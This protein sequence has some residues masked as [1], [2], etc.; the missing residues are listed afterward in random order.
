[1]RRAFGP[2]SA[3]RRGNDML[4]GFKSKTPGKDQ[5]AK[6]LAA[7]D[8]A[9]TNSDT[10]KVGGTMVQPQRSLT[11]QPIVKADPAKPQ[12]TSS[13]GAGMSI[14]GTVECNGPAQIFGRI[15]GQ[16]RASDLL[17]GEG[18]QVE[19]DVVAQ[20]VTICG[21]VTGTIRAVRV[22]LQG[23][24][25]VTGDI[26]HKSLSIDEDSL[27]EGS[28][29]RVANPTEAPAN[30]DARGAQRTNAQGAAPVQPKPGDGAPARPEL[31]GSQH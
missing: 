19:G 9:A 26:F 2:G 6:D 15:E 17:I 20:E 10:T 25:A 7:K 23:G 24:G 27:F 1:M 22:R 13:I 3:G 29:R 5:A 18:A 8:L 12:A 28:S 30:A 4:G 31:V 11:E 16:I 21:S 14:V